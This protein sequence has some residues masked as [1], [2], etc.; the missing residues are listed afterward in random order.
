MG[1]KY[2]VGNLNLVSDIWLPILKSKD[3]DNHD[4]E[5]VITSKLQTSD[6]TIEFLPDD[7]VLYQDIFGNTF[8]VNK[9]KILVS[10]KENNID[11][12]SISILGIP[13]GY[14]L[15][16]NNFQVLHGSSVAQNGSAI[17]FI[18]RSGLGKSSLALSL[19]DKGFK[20]VTEDLCIIKNSSIY[21]FSDWVKSDEN[22]LIETLKP[23]ER[24]NL[25][26]DSRQRSLYKLENS[27]VSNK[28]TKL[29]AIYFLDSNKKRN[30]KKVSLLDSFKYLFTYAY[31]KSDAD[32]FSLEKLTKISEQADCFIYSRDIEKPLE[33]NS[34]FILDHIMESL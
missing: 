11:D 18:G 31:R 29:K 2:Q 23:I 28:K 1:F 34:R 12:A 6:K 16:N 7:S 21:N 3:F 24:I 4:L 10:I 13:L 15:Q 22:N 8:L 17:C 14:L 32:A 20:L 19:L 30:I 9:S 5:I 25:E 26:K 33:D 27:Y